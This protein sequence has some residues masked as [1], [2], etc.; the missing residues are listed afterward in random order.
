MRHFFLISLLLFSCARFSDRRAERRFNEPRPE[1]L[2]TPE[3]SLQAKPDWSHSNGYAPQNTDLSFPTRPIENKSIKG[4]LLICEFSADR[5]AP[6]D[7]LRTRNDPFATFTF[8]GD[9]TY[10]GVKTF[11]V[12][13]PLITLTKGDSF[14]VKITDRD[15]FSRNDAMASI[16]MTYQGEFPISE[17]KGGVSIRCSAILREELET[18]LRKRLFVLEKELALLGEKILSQ[19]TPDSP[20]AEKKLFSPAQKQLSEIASLIGWDDPSVAKRI[21]QLKTLQEKRRAHLQEMIASISQAAASL[22]EGIE[23]GG[24]L[25]SAQL[26]C[27]PNNISTY[28]NAIGLSHLRE[29]S[30]IIQLQI[31]NTGNKNLVCCQG[32]ELYLS[33]SSLSLSGEADYIDLMGW[34]TPSG[35]T[36]EKTVTLP[37]QGEGTQLWVPRTMPGQELTLLKIRAPTKSSKAV[38]MKLE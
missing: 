36:E 4:A 17:K 6:R 24:L 13:A 27:D 23:V 15:F 18:K 9:S 26:S 10:G 16:K 22:G 5:K 37:P 12:T 35:F 7:F 1:H 14:Q 34:Q 32:S 30:C 29:H 3:A 11:R 31:K 25:V 2:G 8:N 20:N 33:T 21:A 38:Y 28:K 19:D